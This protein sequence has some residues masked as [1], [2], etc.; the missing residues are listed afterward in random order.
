MYLKGIHL[1]LN[2]VYLQYN[3]FA[4]LTFLT[5]SKYSNFSTTKVREISF[6]LRKSCNQKF[7]INYS[8]K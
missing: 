1:F 3:F 6:Y 5:A 7:L 2:E 8:L 4:Q